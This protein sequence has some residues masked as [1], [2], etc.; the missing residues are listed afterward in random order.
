MADGPGVDDAIVFFPFSETSGDAAGDVA[1]G[2]TGLLRGGA[3]LAAPGK[4]GSGLALPGAGSFVEIAH[5]AGDALASGTLAFWVRPEAIGAA[6]GL[7]SKDAIGAGAGEMTVLLRADGRVSFRLETET[8]TFYAQSQ[9]ALD[10]GDWAHVAVSWG[11]DGM[12]LHLDGALDG[13]ASHAGGLL[14]AAEP[15][16]IGADASGA[17]LRSHFRG[18]IDEVTLF[19]RQ[20][21]AADL[22]ALI[23]GES[24][25]GNAAPVVA[26]G[27]PDHAATVGEAFSFAP[28][29]GA[30]TDPDGDAL[31]LTASRADGGALPDWLGFDGARFDGTPPAGAAGALALRVTASD[32]QAS[33]QDAFTL[34]IAAPAAPATGKLSFAGEIGR[35]KVVDLAQ[36]F[37][38]DAPRVM[39]LGDSITAGASQTLASAL[40]EGP[41][42]DLWTL[43]TRDGGFIDYVGGLS[44]GPAS[45]PDR[46]HRGVGGIKAATVVGQADDLAGAYRPDVV[47]L[48]LGTNDLKFAQNAA[49]TVP[50]YLMS[51]MQSFARVEPGVTILLGQTPPIDPSAPGYK[52]RA[53]ADVHRA[54]LV[55]K[56][57]GL[58]ADARALGIDARYVAMP[59]LTEGDLFDGIHPNPGGYAKIAGYWF[60]ALKAGLAQGEFGGPRHAT[61]GVRDIDGSELGDY[62]RGD[63]AANRIFGR[64]GADRIEGGGGADVL[65][66]GA[67]PDVF[68]F[69]TAAEGADRITDFGTKDFIEVSAAGFGGG[70]VADGPVILRSGGA[71]VVQDGAGQFLYDR[72]DGHLSWDHDGTGHDVAVLVAKLANLPTLGA[73]DFLVI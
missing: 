37:W 54:E 23:A 72:D 53:D 1:G 62:L 12:R 40:M 2:R 60:E 48:M 30:F 69:R 50:G 55:A 46:D 52:Y 49:T 27:V 65:T 35:A 14:G 61:A 64:K 33:A 36:G 22:A 21:G 6:Q 51:I 17:G 56:L 25:G 28:P 16:V 45:L 4:V 13:A 42:R 8:K 7:V 3:S 19:D 58:A 44:N 70:L 10:A 67:D 66:G 38:A 26:A 5:D 71:P 59:G 57:P 20:L 39:P 11:A 41:R 34:T 29:A 63:G 9:R 18:G 47:L 24:G 68:V 15:W 73:G 32:G 31:T 43:I